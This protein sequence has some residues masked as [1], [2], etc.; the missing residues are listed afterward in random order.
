[1]G[2]Q[3]VSQSVENSTEYIFEN[4]VATYILEAFRVML[5]ALLGLAIPNQYCQDTR[6]VL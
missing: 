6:M 1:M 2:R 4:F 3:A 5:K